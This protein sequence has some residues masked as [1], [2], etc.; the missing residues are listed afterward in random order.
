MASK[1]LPPRL[2]E[3]LLQHPVT[4]QPSADQRRLIGHMV[5]HKP[6]GTKGDLGLKVIG[7]RRTE[8]GRLGAFVTRVKRGSVADVV[9]RLRTGSCPLH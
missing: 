7:G 2:C 6:Q 1:R 8:T 9:G 5:L 3:L 4:W